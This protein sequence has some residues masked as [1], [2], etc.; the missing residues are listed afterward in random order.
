MTLE[1][2]VE[3]PLGG[4]CNSTRYGGERRMDYTAPRIPSPC[5]AGE[6]QGEGRREPVEIVFGQCLQGFPSPHSFVAGMRRH[7]TEAALVTLSLIL[8]TAPY[9][10]RLPA[11]YATL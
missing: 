2:R 7:S 4:T 3:C 11:D 6:G 9:I 5:E 8:R 10:G 1:V